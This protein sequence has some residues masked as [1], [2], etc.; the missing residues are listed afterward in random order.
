MLGRCVAGLMV[1]SVAA[2]LSTAAFG[3]ASPTSP[4]FSEET[5][6]AVAGRNQPRDFFP[7]WEGSGVYNF[8][9]LLLDLNRRVERWVPGHYTPLID[10][11]TDELFCLVARGTSGRGVIGFVS[12]RRCHDFQVGESWS[13]GELRTSVLW[14]VE[15]PPEPIRGYLDYHRR[16]PTHFYYLGDDS[17]PLVLYEYFVG[18]GVV[19]II[20]GLSSYPDLVGDVRRGLD[21]ETLPPQHRLS[22]NTLDYFAR[23]R[24][25]QSDE[26]PLPRDK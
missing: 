11:T 22:L 2:V 12:P 5:P 13:V 10:C 24:W 20:H 1:A 9:G 23:C 25:R 14:K 16:R 3:A 15:R 8:G 4:G 17:N 21:P 7:P 18:S 6:A 26:D 19:A